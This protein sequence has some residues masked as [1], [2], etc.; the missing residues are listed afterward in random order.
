MV[1]YVLTAGS[2]VSI[3]GRYQCK[4]PRNKSCICNTLC[5]L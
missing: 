5:A 4:I 3:G 1:I 2:G